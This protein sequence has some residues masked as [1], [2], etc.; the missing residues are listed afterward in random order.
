MSSKFSIVLLFIASIL[1]WGCGKQGLEKEPAPANVGVTGVQLSREKITV[2]IDNIRKL[3]INVFPQNATE[4]SVNWKSSDPAVASV[5]NEGTVSGHQTGTATIT[6][7]TVDG[8]KTASCEVTVYKG[9]NGHA[10]VEMGDGLKWAVCNIGADDP[11]STGKEQYFAWGETS[12]KKD[13][14]KETYAFWSSSGYENSSGFTKY[15]RSDGKNIL[16][17][18]DDA[19]I[20]NWGGSWRMPT[21]FE[22][23]SLLDE[24]KF[25][26]QWVDDFEG[27]KV[28]GCV[29]TSKVKGFEGNQLFFPALGY[30]GSTG[31]VGYFGEICRYWSSAISPFTDNPDQAFL[32]RISVELLSNASGGF[33]GNLVNVWF[34]HNGLPIRPVS[35]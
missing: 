1:F 2:V 24:K 31:L 13:Y 12:P 17:P 33:M 14:S 29:V 22:F 6:V 23:R 34:R 28:S 7:T 3:N 27:T 8:N 9:L 11:W 16:D 35:E 25:D 26:W 20:K 4:K 30:L 18:D 21:H 10:Y 32:L 5:D 19:A 15:Y